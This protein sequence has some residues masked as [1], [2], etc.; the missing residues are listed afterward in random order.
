VTERAFFYGTVLTKSLFDL[1]LRLQKLER[2]GDIFLHLICCAGTRMIKQGADGL[3]RGNL[4][5]GVMIG[6][7]MLEYVPIHLLALERVE[8]LHG[9]AAG[10]ILMLS[11]SLLRTGITTL[12]R[13]LAVGFGLLLPPLLMQHSS[14]CVMHATHALQRFMLL[15]YP[16]S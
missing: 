2:D 8:H 13:G 3:S 14:N 16:M 1:V 15:R 10:L 4:D 5:N 6:E 7:H 12:I 11:S 9:S